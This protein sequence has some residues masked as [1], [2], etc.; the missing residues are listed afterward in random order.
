MAGRMLSLE[1][2]PEQGAWNAPPDR[3]A[4]LR[5]EAASIYNTQTSYVGRVAN[6]NTITLG[7]RVDLLGKAVEEG[8][9]F[10]PAETAAYLRLQ[11]RLA[12]GG[13]AH[14]GNTNLATRLQ[15][16]VTPEQQAQGAR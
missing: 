12:Y 1:G 3:L 15:L 5:R 4:A 10:T 16:H 13:P 9:S 7:R 6:P 8:R 14:T 2:S 11:R